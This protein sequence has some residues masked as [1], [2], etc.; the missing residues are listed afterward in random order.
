MPRWALVELIEAAARSGRSDIAADALHRLAV[1]TSASGTDWARGLEARSRATLTE[2]EAAERLY[3]EAI[4]RLDRTSIRTELA[5][6]RLLYGEW[7]RRERR[8]G[9][10]RAQL[11][12]AND[13]FEAMGMEAFAERA[14]RELRATGET[15]PKPSV[16]T[17][18][19]QL[20]VQESQIARLARDG[21]SNPEIGA[22]L[23]LSARTVQYHLKKV[24]I[25]L[26]IESRNQLWRVLAD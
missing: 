8:R 19:D 25:K 17:S 26:G 14:R 10:A 13:M 16:S 23:F 18:D 15:A 21:L 9:D 20:T 11:R 2:G 7:L 3:R 22:R 6:A 5:R 4:E 12:I 24:F 1:D